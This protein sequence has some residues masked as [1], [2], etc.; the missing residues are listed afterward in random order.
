M[1]D[2]AP[3]PG[4]ERVSVAGFA[5]ATCEVWA[6]ASRP[7]LAAVIARAPLEDRVDRLGDLWLGLLALE[8]ALDAAHY[9]VAN[10]AAAKA[11]CP[12]GGLDVAVD[13]CARPSQRRGPHDRPHRQRACF[14]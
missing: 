8:Q 12:L 14:P 2:P 13:G 6:R 9:L 4:T 11:N 10:D 7:R 1:T 5:A 3:I